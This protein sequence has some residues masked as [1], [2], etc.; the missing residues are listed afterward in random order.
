MLAK[1]RDQLSRRLG[2]ARRTGIQN[3]RADLSIINSISKKIFGQH[4]LS[5]I[6]LSFIFLSATVPS[7]ADRLE[8]Y[9]F[10]GD[11][12]PLNGFKFCMLK[13]SAGLNL[14]RVGI[15]MES[16]Y[17]QRDVRSHETKFLRTK[18]YST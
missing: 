9:F 3:G 4:S 1:Y 12:Y 7:F 14:K 16:G 13:Q 15:G 10:Q 6:F 5:F 18:N 8:Q 11:I 17:F 2:V